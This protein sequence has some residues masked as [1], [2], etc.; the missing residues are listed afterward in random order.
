MIDEVK[1]LRERKKIN[2]TN[3]RIR[4]LRACGSAAIIDPEVNSSNKIEALLS[5]LRDNPH[6]KVIVFSQWADMIKIIDEALD[7]EDISHSVVVGTGSKHK[8]PVKHI[9]EDEFK[10]FEHECN[11]MI[12]TDAI[13]RSQDFPY[14]SVIIHVDLPWNPATI[15]QRIMRA[16]R[17]SSS[18]KTIFAFNIVSQNTIEEKVLPVLQA[19]LKLAEDII[20]NNEFQSEFESKMD[21]YSLLF[22]ESA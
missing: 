13:S 19:K 17:I 16:R 15:K 12:A 20:D 11:V 21:L 18:H 22:A 8:F 14:A 2:S 6:R 3:N 4:L 7:K 5:I 9:D 10:K 1:E